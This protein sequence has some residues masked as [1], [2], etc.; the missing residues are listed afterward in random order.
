MADNWILKSKCPE[1]LIL[2]DNASL[3]VIVDDEGNF[4]WVFLVIPY[5]LIYHIIIFLVLAFQKCK[6][7][8]VI[9]L[10]QNGKV[11]FISMWELHPIQKEF[12]NR[13]WI[14][15]KKLH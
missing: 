10:Y 12:D 15:S 13:K 2:K 5:R 11:Y 9:L 1:I 7:K 8:T 3:K 4:L 6:K 14:A